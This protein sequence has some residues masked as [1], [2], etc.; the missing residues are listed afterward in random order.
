MLYTLFTRL[1]SQPSK[2]YIMPEPEWRGT[3]IPEGVKIGTEQNNYVPTI[4]R[5]RETGQ[6][7]RP[8]LIRRGLWGEPVLKHVRVSEPDEPLEEIVGE[9]IPIPVRKD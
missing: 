4:I 6:A 3:P 2:K 1:G 7:Y 8:I 9:P 5:D